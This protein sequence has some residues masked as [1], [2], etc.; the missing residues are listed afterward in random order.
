MSERAADISH[1]MGMGYCRDGEVVRD[2]SWW[3]ALCAHGAH[4]QDL[5]SRASAVGEGHVPELH[6]PI[7]M[8]WGQGPVIHHR[9]LAVNELK[10]LLRSS[11]SLHQAAVDGANGLEGKRQ[12]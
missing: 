4:L 9:W 1:G 3:G 7:H 10:H 12:W 2:A 8:V 6:L 11:H 5:C